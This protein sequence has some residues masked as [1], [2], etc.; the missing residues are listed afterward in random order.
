MA[1]DWLSVQLATGIGFGLAGGFVLALLHLA[2]L[3]VNVRLYLTPGTAWRP[4]A[5]HV[6]RLAVVA[7]SFA[8]AASFGAPTLIACLVGFS[9]GR[10]QVL[11]WRW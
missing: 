8:I 9:L 3:A 2:A 10:A 4:I 6:L 5:V 1:K 11:G 7:S